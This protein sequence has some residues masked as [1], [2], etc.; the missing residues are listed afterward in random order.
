M[1]LSRREIFSGP[2]TSSLNFSALVPGRK[3]TLE[4]I[5]AVVDAERC[6]GCRSCLAVCPYRAIAYNDEAE[7]AEVNPVLCMGCG[8]CAAACPTGAIRS[9]HFTNEQIFAEIEGALA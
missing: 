2:G 1:S 9:R 7:S 3:L 6:S 5:Y 8:T 4:A